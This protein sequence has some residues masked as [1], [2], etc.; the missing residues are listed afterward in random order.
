MATANLMSF[1]LLKDNYK[2]DSRIFPEEQIIERFE[3]TSIILDFDY[4][5]MIDEMWDNI[6]DS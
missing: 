5:M 3:D 2:S 6:L 4:E 1:D